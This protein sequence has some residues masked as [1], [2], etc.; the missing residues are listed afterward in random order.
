MTLKDFIPPIVTK[1]IKRVSNK[2]YGSPIHPF[3]SIPSSVRPAWFLDIGANVGDMTIKALKSYPQCQAIC[4]EP[5]TQTFT[6]LT[7]NLT[8]YAGRHTLFNLGL[9]NS[10]EK[11]D[12]NITN[13]HGA[14]SILPQSELH[15][16]V[17]GVVEVAKEQI[18][19]VK[20]DEISKEFPSN[21]IDVMKIDVEGF[22]L[23]VLQGGYNFISANVDVIMIEIAPY[24]IDDFNLNYVSSIFEF[25]KSAGFSLINVYDLESI[26]GHPSLLLG[27]MDCVFRRNSNL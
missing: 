25:M 3:D 14:N 11:I 5:V 19:L 24:R 16:K 18:Q 4:F 2:V 6:T 26:N 15:K 17:T 13:F 1:V 7:Q 10:Q 23:N 20:L 12:I 27:Q 21:K 8:D 22:E 9:S